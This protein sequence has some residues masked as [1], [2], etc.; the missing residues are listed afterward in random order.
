MQNTCRYFIVIYI[1]IFT[2]DDYG[3]FSRIGQYMAICDIN[4]KQNVWGKKQ[5]CCTFNHKVSEPNK[6]WF[7]TDICGDAII[8][9]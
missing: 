4:L 6:E 5:K 2:S 7:T 1:D 3:P 9:L 8:F